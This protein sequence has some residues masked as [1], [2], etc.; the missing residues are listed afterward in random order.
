MQ[1][2]LVDAKVPRWLRP[3]LPLVADAH[4]IVWLPGLRLADPVKLTS[5][6]VSVLEIA[7]SPATTAAIRVWDSLLAWTSAS[8]R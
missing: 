7:I 8:A 1:D 6:T 3:H 5:K 2:F 4:G